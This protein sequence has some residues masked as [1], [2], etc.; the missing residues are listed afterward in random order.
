VYNQRGS[1]PMSTRTRRFRIPG[2]GLAQAASVYFIGG[3]ANRLVPVALMPVL[4]RVLDTAGYGLVG[5]FT[6]LENFITPLANLNL[7]GAIQRQYYDREQ[8]DFPRYVGNCT[9]LM[10]AATVL[11]LGLLQLAGPLIERWIQFPREWLWAVALAALGMALG[12]TMLA[13]WQ[14]QKR[15][16]PYI[17]FNLV[18]SLANFGLSVWLIAGLHWD[19]SGRVVGQLIAACATGALALVIQQLSGLSRWRVDFRQMRAALSF[20][21]PLLPHAL[22]NAAIALTTRSF[23]AGAEGLGSAGVFTAGQQLAL[24]LYMANDAFNRAYVPWLFERL[25]QNKP[26]VLRK[27][28]IGTYFGFGLE[29]AAAVLLGTLAP[30]LASFIVG[31]KFLAA[32][33]YVLLLALGFAFDG[34]YLLVTNYIFYARKTRFLAY[35]TSTAAL[36]NL[37]LCWLLVPRYGALG[38]CW[39]TLLCYAVKFALTFGLAQRAHPLPWALWRRAPEE[40]S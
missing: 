23:V 31:P 28:V 30:W 9:L 26:A 20:G 18:F 35:T 21:L 39:A 3:L 25:K 10:G 38:A 7:H 11:L 24:A 1:Q 12:Q 17:A 37:A 5:I 2:A 22:G 34:M 6:S 19:W 40:Q 15:P 33:R 29:V 4:T 32:A 16:W 14:V 27:L 8:S 13:L 36:V